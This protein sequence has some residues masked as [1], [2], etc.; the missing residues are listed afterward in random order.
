[1]R[2]YSEYLPTAITRLMATAALVALAGCTSSGGS[3]KALEDIARDKSLQTQT[4]QQVASNT[5]SPS[6]VSADIRA[7]CP[8]LDLLEPYFEDFP[9]GKKGDPEALRFQATMLDAARNCAYE[10]N[11][12]ILSVGARGRVITGPQGNAGSTKLPIR[13]AVQ[14]GASVLFSEL[15]SETATVGQEGRASLCPHFAAV[16]SGTKTAQCIY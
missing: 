11:E 15:Y 8:Q 6:T 3:G 10:G 5:V 13:I 9:R 2:S 12:L 7:Y 14:S 16:C 1:M 4:D